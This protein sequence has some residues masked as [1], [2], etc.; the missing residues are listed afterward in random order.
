MAFIIF[1]SSTWLPRGPAYSLSL[2]LFSSSLFILYRHS[3]SRHSLSR[4]FFSLSL[5][6]FSSRLA[7]P[8]AVGLGP[9][10]VSTDSSSPAVGSPA[11]FRTR[12]ASW[13]ISASSCYHAAA[14][15]VASPGAR[16]SCLVA[17]ARACQWYRSF[18]AD[19]IIEDD[20]YRAGV[21]T[22]E[23]YQLHHHRRR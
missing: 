8:S 21:Y 10:L 12:S 13:V 7:A 3:V 18:V 23:K 17:A 15:P 9:S 16:V 14:S 11:R 20:V 2:S 4:H 6:L 22:A 5:S 19:G 1:S